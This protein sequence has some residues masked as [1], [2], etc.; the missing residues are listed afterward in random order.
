MKQE[1][2]T[3]SHRNSTVESMSPSMLRANL[4]RQNPVI[5]WLLALEP[6]WAQTFLR[7]IRN[8]PSNMIPSL[9]ETYLP[10]LLENGRESRSQPR[11][12]SGIDVKIPFRKLAQ[13][14]N[15]NLVALKYLAPPTLPIRQPE[16]TTGFT[17]WPQKPRLMTVATPLTTQHRVKMRCM[18]VSSQALWFQS[19]QTHST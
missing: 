2:L 5:S 19:P 18:P 6:V 11:L 7:V 12:I 10:L 9:L 14:L 17:C 13:H 4:V 16:P 15:Q 3:P 8:L 1:Q